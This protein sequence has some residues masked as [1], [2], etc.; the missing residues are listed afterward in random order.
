[1]NCP[2]CG[3]SAS[4]FIYAGMPVKMCL[5]HRPPL[6]LGFFGWLLQFIPFN[7]WFM[8]YEG[9]YWRAFVAWWRSSQEQ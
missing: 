6:V 1:M 5:W 7:G 8:Q 2:E 3:K 9:S 4:K